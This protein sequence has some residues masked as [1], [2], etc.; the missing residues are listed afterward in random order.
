MIIDKQIKAKKHEGK[1][2]RLDMVKTIIKWTKNEGKKY[3]IC[4]Y[5]GF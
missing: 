1:Q 4:Y 2:K 5:S 3:V